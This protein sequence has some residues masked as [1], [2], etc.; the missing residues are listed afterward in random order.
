MNF[1]AIKTK[2]GAKMA[3][4]SLVN[5]QGTFEAVAFPKDYDKFEDKVALDGIY[6]FVGYFDNKKDPTNPQF[7]VKEICE[8]SELKT[9][10]ISSLVI[11]LNEEESAGENFEMLANDLKSYFV[12]HSGVFRVKGSG[13][14]VQYYYIR[15]HN[16][17]IGDG[18]LF[19][20]SSA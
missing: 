18:N 6:G 3:T 10:A 17:D 13:G 15:V 8:P 4:Y 5:Y 1:R 2:T 9:E 11:E 20:L 16:E 12:D 7:I 19:F 14:L